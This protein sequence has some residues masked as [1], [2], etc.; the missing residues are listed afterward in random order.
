[1][2]EFRRVLAPRGLMVLM[3]SDTR[4]MRD[5]LDEHQIALN[6]MLPVKVLGAAAWIHFRRSTQ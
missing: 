3:I 4:L 6:S 2:R 5:L 1:M